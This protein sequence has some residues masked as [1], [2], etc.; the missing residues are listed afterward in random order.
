M[1]YQTQLQTLKLFLEDKIRFCVYEGSLRE[2]KY[3]KKEKRI[4]GEILVM[5]RDLN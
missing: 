4:Y 2:A 1:N 5:L 3:L